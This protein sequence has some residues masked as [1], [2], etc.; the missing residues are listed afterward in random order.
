MDPMLRVGC[1]VP[2]DPRVS[3]VVLVLDDVDMVGGCLESLRR[4][5]DSSWRPEI[6]VVA[7][8]TSLSRLQD[9]QRREDIVLVRS[10]TNLGFAGGNNLGVGAA[11]GE[12]LVFVNDDAVVEPDWLDQLAVTAGSDPRIG[13]V[14]SRILFEDG[15]LQEAGAVIWGDG[16]T[17]AVGRDLP[18]GSREYGYVRDVDY[19]SANGMLVRRD[20]WEAVGGFAGDYHPAYYEDV[21]LCMAMR[22]AGRRVVYEPRSV[23]RHREGGSSS[24]RYRMFL[25]GYQRN[26]FRQKWADQIAGYERYPTSDRAAAI[27]R[28]LHRI[29]GH[30]PRVLILDDA[31]P[32]PGLGSGFGRAAAALEELVG[33]GFAVTFRPF[34]PRLGDQVHTPARTSVVDHLADL[35]VDVRY[36]HIG[37]LLRRSGTNFDVVLCSRPRSYGELQPHLGRLR[38]QVPVIYDTEAIWS[39]GLQRDAGL[40]REP[41]QSAALLRTAEEIRVTEL[42]AIGRADHVVAVS[43]EEAALIAEMRSEADADPTAVTVIGGDSQP[44]SPGPAGWSERRNIVFPAGWLAGVNSP[45]LTSLRHFVDEILP[46]VVASIPWVRILV[47]G[48]NPPPEALAL[49]GPNVEFLGYVP[50]MRSVLDGARVVAVP[51]RSGAGRKLKTSE[52]M[53]AGVPTVSTGLGAEGIDVSERGGLVVTDDPGSFAEA[54]VSL[55]ED[56]RAW[57]DARAR[58]EAYGAAHDNRPVTG[59]ADLLRTAIHQARL[60]ATP[61]RYHRW[62]LETQPSEDELAAQRS[63]AARFADRPTIS[64]CVPVFEPRISWLEETL[65]TVTAQTYDQ[66]ELC[67]VDDCSPDP[68]V[69]DTLQRWADR[70]PRLKTARRPAN[71]GISAATNDALA[72][73]TGEFVAFLDQDDLLAPQA[74]Y[75]VV[76]HLQTHP[77]TDLFYCDEDLLGR[78]RVRRNPLLKP[79]WSPD[80]LLSFN[81]I[82]HLVVARRSL[83]VAVGGLRSRFDGSQDHDLLLRL[84]ERTDAVHHFDEVLYTWRQSP[85]SSS[86][87]PSAKPE[88]H[89]ATAEAVADALAR[90]DIGGTVDL[91][92]FR[93]GVV[94]RYE[95]GPSATTVVVTG[96]N[97]ALRATALQSMVDR[98]T[99]GAP[100]V[101]VPVPAG[102]LA[103]AT[104]EQLERLGFRVLHVPGDPGRSEL[105][106]AAAA[107][108]DS[109]YLL[110]LDSN[111]SIAGRGWLDTLVGSVA[112]G[113]GVV[114]IRLFGSDGRSWHEGIALGPE[115]PARITSGPDDFAGLQMGP[116]LA[117][118]RNV[119]AVSG[120]CMLVRR[121]AW[122]KVG[123]WDPS[124][125]DPGADVD[126]CVRLSKAG[127]RV[128]L[129]P[130]VSGT[131]AEPA[132]DGLEPVPE[133]VEPVAVGPDPYFSP[134]L[135]RTGAGWGLPPDARE[136]P[137]WTGRPGGRSGAH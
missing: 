76:D 114:G 96:P 100:E 91:G 43:E 15:S 95:P 31:L 14:G 44:W 22:R 120:L 118:A 67:L 85:S 53:L 92:R 68:A 79:G 131:L 136:A 40:I 75:R 27:E 137:D 6:V 115:G 132:P 19:V 4:T 37:P 52:A 129:T 10:E 127:Y 122:D 73:A 110:I 50:D 128:L 42:D 34:D 61:E 113:V 64:I 126:F 54:L 134:H 66:F 89:Q 125:P 41:E 45:N 20:A 71:G 123:G 82:T 17:S 101:V 98:G 56:P 18:A 35:G 106:G 51:A 119:S 9:L 121:D 21:D 29:G 102:S 81:Y 104:T 58:L 16:P 93:G 116:L 94:V 59:W 32:D 57:A 33:A 65:A 108:S 135:V 11:R 133:R 117:S 36:E 2:D 124:V 74:L 84:T 86:F 99:S 8:G 38:S 46:R 77:G 47:T 49:A 63:R 62:L 80:T 69:S 90:R 130:D 26:V 109:K 28:A 1:R 23:V 111:L 112:P 5:I 24:Y 12:L 105:L 55:H 83:V 7:N 78:D 107:G 103:P 70:D 39:R 88:A 13:A 25:M 60:R 48:G 3:I 30:P 72:L 97:P 87:D